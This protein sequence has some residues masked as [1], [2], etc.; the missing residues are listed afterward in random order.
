M[1][2]NIHSINGL[3][4]VYHFTGQLGMSSSSTPGDIN[5]VVSIGGHTLYTIIEILNT[6]G[7]LWRKVFETEG[8]FTAFLRLSEYV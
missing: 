2:Q 1:H 5:K 8:R 7:S 3:S 6:L 4:G